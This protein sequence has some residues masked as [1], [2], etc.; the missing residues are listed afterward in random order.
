MSAPAGRT[1]RGVAGAWCFPVSA[2]NLPPEAH[3]SGGKRSV[4]AL[5]AASRS[6]SFGEGGREDGEALLFS[7]LVR[8]RLSLPRTSSGRSV[9]G[10]LT[11]R[12]WVRRQTG[13]PVSSPEAA[14]SEMP[15]CP[16]GCS[17]EAHPREAR[18]LR[19]RSGE[20]G[21]VSRLPHVS[22][23]A[24]PH[25]RLIRRIREQAVDQEGCRPCSGRRGRCRLKPYAGGSLFP[26]ARG[27]HSAPG[28][29]QARGGGSDRYAYEG[30]R[31]PLSSGRT[32]AGLRPGS[33]GRC[34]LPSLSCCLERAVSAFF[35]LGA[36]LCFPSQF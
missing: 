1:P 3:S 26:G 32:G 29:G 28:P 19:Y 9:A 22:S 12:P 14:F 24:S 4:R 18:W 27:A 33:S 17:L 2:S 10:K 34:P 23:S 35:A 7:S 13:D 6:G 21:A 36:G 25:L 30:V 5:I 16:G 20:S 31:L 11:G 15:L 8:G